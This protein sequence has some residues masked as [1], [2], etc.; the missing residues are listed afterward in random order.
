MIPTLHDN[1]L[2]KRIVGDTSSAVDGRRVASGSD[3][4]ASVN[5]VV[6]T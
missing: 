5:L 2:L 3:D 6:A 4:P 1:D